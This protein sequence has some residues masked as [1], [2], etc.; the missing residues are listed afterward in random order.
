M[1]ADLMPRGSV[2]HNIVAEYIKL[3]SSNYCIRSINSIIAK[4][5][6]GV[7][8]KCRSGFDICLWTAKI[9]MYKDVNMSVGTWG[10]LTCVMYLMNQ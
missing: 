5:L 9:Y 4:L 2:F 8:N 1:G 6:K 3:L 7:A 10:I